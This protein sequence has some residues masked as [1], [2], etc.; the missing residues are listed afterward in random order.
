MKCPVCGAD[1]MKAG[2]TAYF[3]QVDGC[4]IIIENVP[5]YTCSQCG[6]KVYSASVLEKIDDI[7]DRFRKLP[8]KLMIMDYSKAA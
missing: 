8:E 2:K 6:E 5:C 7:I 1:L 4:Y 3:A